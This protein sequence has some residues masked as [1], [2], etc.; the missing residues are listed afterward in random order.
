MRLLCCSFLWLV[1]LLPFWKS[2]KRIKNWVTSGFLSISSK[3]SENTKSLVDRHQLHLSI[4]FH[5]SRDRSP[6]FCPIFEIPPSS[7]FGESSSS[8][9]R[10]RWLTLW[11]VMIICAK[12]AYLYWHMRV[13]KLPNDQC[14]TFLLGHINLHIICHIW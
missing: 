6:P 4:S 9:K 12:Y 13:I 1:V 14:I 7:N 3:H 5:P 8:L 10:A 2:T 11:I